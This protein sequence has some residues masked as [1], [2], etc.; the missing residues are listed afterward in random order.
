MLVIPNP[1][2]RVRDLLFALTPNRKADPSGKLRPRNDNLAIFLVARISSL[3][4]ARVRIR[5]ARVPDATL[6]PAHRDA[7]LAEACWLCGSA[8][9]GHR[10]RR[11]WLWWAA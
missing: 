3:G 9:D 4:A 8:G 10:S 1:R 5:G 6:A 7:P 2:Q 11:P